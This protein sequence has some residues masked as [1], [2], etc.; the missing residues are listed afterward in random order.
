MA[1][2]IP[3]YDG[4]SGLAE[5]LTAAGVTIGVDAVRSLVAGV[6]GAPEGSLPDGWINLIV[7]QASESLREQLRAL[8]VTMANEQP[9]NP[10]RL[11]RLS[12]LREELMRRGLDGFIVPRTDEH[13]GEY[14]PPRAD[15]LRWLTR[16]SGSAGEAVIL[17]DR[18]AIFVD[19]RYTLQVR[20][21]VDTKMIEPHH[22]IETTPAKWIAE[23]LQT[24]GKLGYDPWLHSENAVVLLRT[25]AERAGGTLVPQDV[26]AIDAIWKD[27]PAAPIAPI[28]PHPLE[29]TGKPAAEKRKDIGA[30]IVAEGCDAAVLTA[31]DSIAWL[32]NVRGGDVPR[33]PMPLS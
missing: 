9:A 1:A 7:P 12:M 10:P 30:A 23:N 27:Q 19:G 5:R 4:D 15:R 26:N 32:L 21:Q 13:Q 16:F 33:A 6:N 11:E 18:A 8:K 28:N 3:S 17:K 29:F 2:E 22:L 25:A 14:V 31:P 20:S 24:G